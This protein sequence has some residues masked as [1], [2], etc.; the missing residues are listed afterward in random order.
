M[1]K[2]ALT[3]TALLLAVSLALSACNDSTSYR[4]VTK[5][6]ETA[7]KAAEAV[8]KLEARYEAANKKWLEAQK[9][10]QDQIASANAKIGEFEIAL[11][12]T[13]KWAGSR[14]EELE[15]SKE[16]VQDQLESVEKE[17]A[18]LKLQIQNE[19]GDPG[20]ILRE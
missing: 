3:N 16:K 2:N 18:D 10:F 12:E 8:N 17:L 7:R 9:E 14:I 6:L 4:E 13:N 1:T 20:R 11:A 5:A 19:I 15:Q